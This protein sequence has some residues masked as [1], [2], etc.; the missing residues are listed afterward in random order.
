MKTKI[1][2][3]FI[4]LILIYLSYNFYAYVVVDCWVPDEQAF[5][6]SA[7]SFDYGLK[8]FIFFRKSVWVWSIVLWVLSIANHFDNFKILRLLSFGYLT[9]ILILIWLIGIKLGQSKIFKIYSCLF[10]ILSLIVGF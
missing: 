9:F 1:Y 2:A 4:P 10:L 8:D 3:I 6:Q 7:I 5:F